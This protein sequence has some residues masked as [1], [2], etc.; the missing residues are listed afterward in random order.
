MAISLKE[1]KTIVTEALNT[2][3]N[4]PKDGTISWSLMDDLHL[5]AIVQHIKKKFKE[6]NFDVILS[7][8]DL[9]ES[10]TIDDLAK[11]C[12]DKEVEK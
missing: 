11:Y 1:V 7:E 12:Y 6:Q 5:S 9:S 8:E 2:V 10:K 3:G 4:L